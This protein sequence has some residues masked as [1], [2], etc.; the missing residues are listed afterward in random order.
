MK[1]ASG[2]F[3]VLVSVAMTAC[4]APDGAPG[5]ESATTGVT[6]QAVNKYNYLQ[7]KQYAQ[8]IDAPGGAF[9]VLLKLSPATPSTVW[10]D[11]SWSSVLL[12]PNTYALVNKSSGLCMEVNN[13]TATPG[14][15][16]DA[17]TCNGSAAEQWRVLTR[18]PVFSHG[19]CQWR[20][21]TMG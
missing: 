9:N 12:A 1:H 18:S 6:A 10:A 21:L 2:W 17:Y 14:E 11:L 19:W 4:G 8:Y 5:D 15:R 16:I 13:G 20:L 7:N 3:T